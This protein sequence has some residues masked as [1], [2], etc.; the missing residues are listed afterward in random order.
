V[1]DLRE[2]FQIKPFFI[3]HPGVP[4]NDDG[5]CFPIVRFAVFPAVGQF[6]PQQDQVVFFK[7]FKGIADIPRTAAG[8]DQRQLIFR[9]EVKGCI[10]PFLFQDECIKTCARRGL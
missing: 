8:Q 1:P 6:W 9:V 3:D 5:V 4:V 2:P 7:V 10:E